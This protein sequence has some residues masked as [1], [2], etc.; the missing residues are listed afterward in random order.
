MSDTATADA[1][2]P[3][4]I[5][6]AYATAARQVW[7]EVTVPAGTTIKQAI[8]TSGVLKQFRDIDLATQK[9]GIFGRLA[10]LTDTVNDGDR[11]EIYRPITADPRQVKRKR[12][13]DAPAGDKPQPDRFN[14]PDADRARMRKG[15][16]R[17]ANETVQETLDKDASPAPMPKERG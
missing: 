16:P 15:P 8:E 2:A 1:P 10:N 6:V 4:K 13:D 7:L 9:V 12:A 11:V 3:L 5:G 17:A 14:R